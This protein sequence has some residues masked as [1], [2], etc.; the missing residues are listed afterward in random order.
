M[1]P[2][3]LFHTYMIPGLFIATLPVLE[4]LNH[5]IFQ[6]GFLRFSK[7]ILVFCISIGL[8]QLNNMSN[9]ESVFGG[10]PGKKSLNNI[11]DIATKKDL[12]IYSDA[13][14]ILKFYLPKLSTKIKD[15]KLI[16]KDDDKFDSKF[17]LFTRENQ[18]Y[19][20]ITF[21]S[22]NKPALFLFRDSNQDIRNKLDYPCNLFEIKGLDGYACIVENFNK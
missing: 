10:F 19:K 8:F 18:E 2:F 20:E 14:N 6:N 5:A 4:L 22:I 1:L 9:Y 12:N 11:T 13:G 15:I 16:K 21:D 7:F 17:K 3:S